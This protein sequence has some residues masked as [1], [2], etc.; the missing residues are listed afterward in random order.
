MT[1]DILIT[2]RSGEPQILF[3]GSGT[4]DTPIEL[5][6]LSSYQ[7]AS[8][9]GTALIFQGTEGQLFSINDNLSSGVIFSV[10]DIAGL[11]FLEIDASGDVRFIEYGRYVGIGTGVPSY[12]LDVFGT[13]R[14]SSGIVFPDGVRQTI[15]YTGQVGGGTSYTA[16]SGLTLDGNEFNVY[17]GTGQFTSS[18]IVGDLIFT[19]NS[20]SVTG[21]SDSLWL[22]PSGQGAIIFSNGTVNTGTNLGINSVSA[23]ME[24]DN[25]SH[26]AYAD[27][28]TIIG[29]RRLEIKSAAE[30]STAIGG[31]QHDT[32]NAA[33]Y[34]T[35]I[36]AATSQNSSAYSTF[37]GPSNGLARD[38]TSQVLGQSVTTTSSYFYNSIL[39]GFISELV[40]SQYGSQVNTLE[41]RIEDSYNSLILSS[42]QCT[43]LGQGFSE[44]YLVCGS[45]NSIN[46]A[47]GS[48]Y[49]NSIFGGSRNT[50]VSG[51]NTNEPYIVFGGSHNQIGS[52]GTRS[53]IVSSSG[54]NTRL[55]GEN[56]ISCNGFFQNTGDAQK[57]TLFLDNDIG[58][59]VGNSIVLTAKSQSNTGTAYANSQ[60]PILPFE[61]GCSW[62]F[63]LTM[64]ICS[65]SFLLGLPSSGIHGVY[66]LKGNITSDS[67]NSLSLVTGTPEKY[68]DSLTGVQVFVEPHTGMNCLL[69][70]TSG[71]SI[72]GPDAHASASLELIYCGGS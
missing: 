68:F 41:S 29:G 30:Y 63:N 71:L 12:E 47:G 17:G 1:Q 32:Q 36:R 23:Q 9:S 55:Y 45:G 3:L 72:Y 58:F 66:F 69:I 52:S 21:D 6:V 54:A 44:L 48:A 39:G 7:S 53:I 59:S 67:G 8:T 18:Y 26:R 20:I 10:D 70:S 51:A 28:S 27:Y 22:R 40:R 50:I 16:G 33:T 43:G 14:F 2:P 42:T 15:A 13:G 34:S 31:S 5:N 19:N 49:I 60:L 24:G 61:Y 4:N 25:T 11:P 46:F 37:L 38:Y 65:N 56:V 64:S 62:N 57:S 35:C